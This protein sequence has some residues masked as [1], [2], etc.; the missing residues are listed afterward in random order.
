MVEKQSTSNMTIVDMV[1]QLSL[2][3]LRG[4]N[5]SPNLLIETVH[6]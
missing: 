5:C 1:Y 4:E 3:P 2:S 6:T